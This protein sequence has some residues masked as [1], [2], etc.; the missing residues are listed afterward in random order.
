MFSIVA[1]HAN[2]S[3]MYFAHE[4]SFRRRAVFL[5][6]GFVEIV[7]FVF[8]IN[9][10]MFVVTFPDL[11]FGGFKGLDRQRL[12]VA[13]PVGDESPS[14]IADRLEK[15]GIPSFAIKNEHGPLSPADFLDLAEVVIDRAD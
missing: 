13:F 9:G 14:G 8:Y 11:G 7:R 12:I 5:R 10:S 6:F 4:F 3:E 15:A 1:Q 2:F